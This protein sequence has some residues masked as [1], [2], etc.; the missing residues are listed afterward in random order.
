[1]NYVRF[2]IIFA[3]ACLC[4]AIVCLGALAAT[5]LIDKVSECSF[6]TEKL[7]LA[8][9]LFASYG[10]VIG[11]VS[12]AIRLSVPNL[13]RTSVLALALIYGSV[14]G[15]AVYG[16]LYLGLGHDDG[17]FYLS[18]VAPFQIASLAQGAIRAAL[19][20]IFISR[21]PT[22]SNRRTETVLAVLICAEIL[23][24]VRSGYDFPEF[25]YV[26]MPP[27]EFDPERVMLRVAH[28]IN[29]RLERLSSVEIYLLLHY[30][31][32]QSKALLGVTVDF[33][34]VEEIDIENLFAAI[35]TDIAEIARHQTFDV[36]KATS[37]ESE[38]FVALMHDAFEGSS[39]PIRE[40]VEFG[41]GYLE[42]KPERINSISFTEA[43]YETLVSRLKSLHR[44]VAKDGNPVID[45]SDYNKWAV[46]VAA[47]YAH[48]PYDVVLTNQLIASATYGNVEIHSAIRGALP[49]GTAAYS[50]SGRYGGFV[51]SS[52]FPFT[53]NSSQI[54]GMRG[55]ESY[56]RMEAAKLAGTYLVHELGHL[57]YRY[58]HPFNETGCVMNPVTLLHF[59]DWY[60]GIVSRTCPVIDTG[61][62]KKGAAN[63][64]RLEIGSGITIVE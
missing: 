33:E 41:D 42:T 46:W 31:K 63:F 12:E 10:A 34:T 64:S 21:P 54:L 22:G 9:V 27:P 53:N 7:H 15:L 29:P 59:R 24:F 57:L 49:V 52:T 58:G 16:Y 50:S 14:G 38:I 47:G 45:K 60:E 39:N 30:F 61:A 44:I 55:G 8:I 2:L 36:E 18:V 40:L 19:A 56:S 35:P 1:M 51:F 6:T 23:F 26:E 28:V 20:R 62:M 48:K 17:Q 3:I 37:Y 5:C 4:F 13:R 43:V 32:V 25:S 11:G